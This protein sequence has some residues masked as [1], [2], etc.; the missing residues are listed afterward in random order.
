MLIATIIISSLALIISAALA[1]VHVAAVDTAAPFPSPA[2][3]IPSFS[4]YDADA[5]L[6]QVVEP[7][8]FI[9]GNDQIDMLRQSLYP[10]KDIKQQPSSSDDSPP[11]DNHEACPIYIAQSSMPNAGLGIYSGVDVSKLE[12]V[13]NRPE[14]AIILSDIN[15]SAFRKTLL[16]H[17]TWMPFNIDQAQF[18][19]SR[20]GAQVHVGIP[21]IGSCANAHHA[22]QGQNIRMRDG[23][24]TTHK[25][26][27]MDRTTDAG[28]G[29][30]SDFYNVHFEARKHIAAGSELFI[31]YGPKWF[32]ERGMKDLPTTE[33]YE[34]ADYVLRIFMQLHGA[35]WAELAP[36]DKE[37]KWTIF[38]EK[39]RTKTKALLPK[40]ADEVPQAA[41]MGSVLF[42]SPETQQSIQWLERNGQC[43]SNMRAGRS[44]IPQAGTGAF[45]TRILQSGEVVSPVPTL[46]IKR[47]LLFVDPK[48]TEQQLLLNY[49]F[50]HKDSSILLY[51]Y[52]ST[53]PLINHG[54]RNANARLQLSTA[55]SE[56]NGELLKKLVENATQAPL[57]LELVATRDI[58]FGE[59][60][61][62]DYGQDWQEAWNFHLST[63]QAAKTYMVLEMNRNDTSVIVDNDADLSR[64]EVQTACH[65]LP[66]NMSK[67]QNKWNGGKRPNV[68]GNQRALVPCDILGRQR[69]R[70]RDYY[71]VRLHNYHGIQE[72]IKKGVDDVVSFVPR[73]AIKYVD[74]PR[75][76]NQHLNGAFRHE[77]TL[78]DGILPAQWLDK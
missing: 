54:G 35:K 49:V 29:A 36:E 34:E 8:I 10:W 58:E 1:T 39:M 61:L 30:M 3:A 33:D 14:V 27:T 59:E 28:T 47:E 31:S 60:I 66:V 38:T 71:T 51:P 18:L 6:L 64:L 20:S 42:N 45:A 77:I 53:V 24:T 37:R 63:W 4:R 65:T 76:N 11:I 2:V 41:D 9:G 74:T 70:N 19:G 22:Q 13:G 55:F 69:I 52:A 50:G 23:K 26:G 68:T 15:N 32:E 40:S 72:K 21:G 17:Y 62:L 57:M 7:A 5:Y 44:T 25:M 46:P 78:P 12:T 43:M 73:W 67:A 75:S 56:M 48:G 16:S